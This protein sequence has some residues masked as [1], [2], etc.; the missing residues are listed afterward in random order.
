MYLSVLLGKQV[1]LH[2]NFPEKS[3]K[4]CGG[5]GWQTI[6]QE[7]VDCP[8]CGGLGAAFQ[9]P[10]SVRYD[11]RVVFSPNYISDWRV[12]GP[13]IVTGIIQRQPQNSKIVINLVEVNLLFRNGGRDY[14]DIRKVFLSKEEAEDSMK[15]KFHKPPFETEEEALLRLCGVKK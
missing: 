10:T 11:G 9:S 7:L 2:Y 12:V 13:A 14:H 1:Y 8:I 4:E 5:C 6:D 15:T 3:C